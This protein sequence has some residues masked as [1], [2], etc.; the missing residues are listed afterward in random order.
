MAKRSVEDLDVAGKRVLM[1]VDFNV[2]QDKE[3][4]SV[5][6][7][8]SRIRKALKTI[9]YIREKG[10]KLILMS[11]LGR[12]KG[13]IVDK[14]RMDPVAK[15]LSEL[16]GVQVKKLDDCIGP[17]VE[18]AVSQ[19]KGGDV[20]LLENVRFHAAEKSKDAAEMMA[21]ARE[22]AKLGDV[23]V[24]DAFGTVHRA[25]ASVAGVPQILT[26][27]AAGY[28]LLKEIKYLGKVLRSPEHPL[29]LILGGAKVSDK[30]QV[31]ENMLD[32]VDKILIGG[33]MCYTFLKARG[34][35][36]G[37]SLFEKD[38][39]DFAK[40][41]LKQAEE[42]GVEVVLP[43]DHVVGRELDEDTET[44]V[45]RDSIEDGWMGLDIGP[46]TCNLFSDKLADARMV[47][48]NGP[49][50]VFEMAPF[51][52]GTRAIAEVLAAS[53]ATTIIGG[54]D[55]AAAVDMMGLADRMSHVS[56][57]GGASLEFLE[58]KELPGIAALPEA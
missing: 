16:L 49:V 56:T 19:M 24:S 13:E 12:P 10:A 18:K 47:V 33:G 11:H 42:K 44:D 36:I 35:G 23:Y 43:V 26:D 40:S 9:R 31:I 37:G 6:T 50:G 30:I 51:A 39:L 57:G 53:S 46:K 15:R 14:L 27:A 7:D 45:Q 38:S 3:D 52:K 4:P 17:Q 22:L 54:G 21:F 58:G 1:R 25:H 48:W 8:D 20:V 29:V 2:P 41:L 34:K 28:L 5:I 32:K 55:T